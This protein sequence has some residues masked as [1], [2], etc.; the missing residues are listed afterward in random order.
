[1]SKNYEPKIIIDDQHKHKHTLIQTL[2]LPCSIIIF[3]KFL[4]LVIVQLIY[5]NSVVKISIYI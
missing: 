1:M 4:I 2:P 3:I 5:I